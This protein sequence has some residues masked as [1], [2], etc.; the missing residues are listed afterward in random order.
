LAG[1]SGS[2]AFP[3]QTAMKDL[4]FV[5]MEDWDEVWRRNQFVCAELSRRYPEIQILFV[6]LPRNLSHDLRRGRFKSS[7][8][9]AMWRVTGFPNITVFHPWKLLPNTLTLGRKINEHL[10]LRQ[11]RKAAGRLGLRSPVLWLNPHDAEHLAGRLAG[12]T[13]TPAGR[14][15]VPQGGCGDRLF[16][17]VI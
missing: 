11:V 1:V 9:R 3:P 4:L 6:A 2:N 7:R 5:S 10:M 8:K 15:A 13:D 16:A 12:R 17:T 14:A